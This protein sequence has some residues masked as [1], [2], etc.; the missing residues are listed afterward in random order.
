M[1][2]LHICES[3]LRLYN[4]LLPVETLLKYRTIHLITGRKCTL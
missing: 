4:V 1:W 3:R 2:G